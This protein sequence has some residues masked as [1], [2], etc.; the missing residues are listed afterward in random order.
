MR[1]EEKRPSISPRLTN[2]PVEPSSRYLILST[3]FGPP[4]LSSCRHNHT[5]II[6]KPS[7]Q[8]LLQATT[9]PGNT[10]PDTPFP[11]LHLPVAVTQTLFLHGRRKAE[12]ATYRQRQPLVRAGQLDSLPFISSYLLHTVLLLRLIMLSLLIPENLGVVTHS[13]LILGPQRYFDGTLLSRV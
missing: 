11:S 10:S 5:C 2:R 3:V 4:R 6:T 12:D 7:L 13:S 1:S 9:V 8:N